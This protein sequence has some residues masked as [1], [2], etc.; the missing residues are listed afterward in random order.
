V[1]TNLGR[2]EGWQHVVMCLEWEDP[3][4]ATFW[5]R[6]DVMEDM[7]EKGHFCVYLCRMETWELCCERGFVQR[8]N[9]EDLEGWQDYLNDGKPSQ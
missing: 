2:P 4:S 9:V 5:L 7:L 8:W 1:A 3:K 6:Q